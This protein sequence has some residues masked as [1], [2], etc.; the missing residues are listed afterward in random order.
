MLFLRCCDFVLVVVVRLLHG[1][2]GYLLL[3]CTVVT[4]LCWV[5][6]V[7]S[8]PSFVPT[9]YLVVDYLIVHLVVVRY[10][11]TVL[12][13]CLTAFTVVGATRS[14]VYGWLFVC[15]CSCCAFAVDCTNGCN[16]VGLS[17]AFDLVVADVRW[18]R[19][20]R[21]LAIAFVLY[22]SPFTA[23]FC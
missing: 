1:I 16:V 3:R 14:C 2:V 21:C 5:A 9:I 19:W 12:P 18:V 15:G 20:V 13:F 4:L 7:V 10:Y 23:T 8:L 6:D 17:D 11:V 22:A